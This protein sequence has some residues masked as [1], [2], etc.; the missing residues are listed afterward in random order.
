LASLRSSLSASSICS[1]RASIIATF[2]S[3]YDGAGGRVAQRLPRALGRH[4]ALHERIESAWL[5]NHPRT[6]IQMSPRLHPA[7]RAYP[8]I[9]LRVRDARRTACTDA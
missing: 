8:H 7:P 6:G 2:R 1:D 4:S 9:V 5:R 3:T